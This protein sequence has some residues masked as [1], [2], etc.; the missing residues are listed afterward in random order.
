MDDILKDDTLRG[1]WPLS[2]GLGLSALDVTKHNHFGF[3]QCCEWK[4]DIERP[5]PFRT[6]KKQEDSMQ[7]FHPAVGAQ[8]TFYTN[9][10][11][12]VIAYP[13]YTFWGKQYHGVAQKFN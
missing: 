3:I 8:A 9:G 6:N 13:A 1:Y 7:L 5:Y 12:L 2:D 10:E 4:Q 11:V